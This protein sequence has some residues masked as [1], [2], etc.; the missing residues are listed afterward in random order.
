[1][2]IKQNKHKNVR[3]MR[4][5]YA[6]L[7]FVI[8]AFALMVISSCLYENIALKK[9]LKTNAEETL[10]QME[11]KISSYFLEPQAVLLTIS[12]TIHDIIIQGG[13]VNNVRKYMDEISDDLR[14]K[15]FGYE[16]AGLHCYLDIFDNTYLPTADWEPP[17]N[18]DATS[19]PWYIAA[20]KAAGGIATSPVYFNMRLNNY[21]VTYSQQIF[22]NNGVPLG[23]VALNVPLA[24][25]QDIVV[26]TRLTKGGYGFLLDEQYTIIAHAN[27]NIIG[28]PLREINSEFARIS[29]L[30]DQGSNVSEVLAKNSLGETGIFF[31]RNIENGWHVGLTAL[32]NEYYR[33]LTEMTIIVSILGAIL[34]AALIFVLIRIDAARNRA[35]EANQQK[36]NFLANIS[37]ELRTPLNV[38][39]GLTDLTLEDANLPDPVSENLYKISNAGNTLLSIVNDLLDF[40]KIESGKLSLIPSEYQISSLLNDVVTLVIT[41]LDESPV[42]FN[43]NISDD[44]PSLLYGDDLRIKQIL[45]NLLSNALKYTFSGKIE[46]SVSCTRESSSDI[47][48][49][50]TVSDTGIGIRHEDLAKLFYAYYQV[51]PKANRNMEGTGLGLPITKRLAEMMNGEITVESEFGKGSKFYVTIRQGYVNDEIIGKTVADNLRNFRYSIGK[52]IVAK[53]MVRDDLSSSKVL[54]VDDVPTNLDVAAGL[55]GKYRIHVDCVNSGPSA[56]ERIQRGHPVYN[57]IFM[58]HMMPGMDGIETADRIR[59]LGTEYSLNIPIIALTANAIYGTEQLFL[60]HGFQDFLSKPID[61]M[62]LDSIVKKWVR[63]KSTKDTTLPPNPSPAVSLPNAQTITIPG[64]NTEKV[65]AMYDEEMDLFKSILRSYVTNIPPELEKI[66]TVTHETLPKY[67]IYVHGIKGASANIGAEAIRKASLNLE[68]MAKAG[69]LDGVLK[70]NAQFIKDIENVI[71]N[72]IIWLKL[73]DADGD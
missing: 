27:K 45:N 15:P 36:S 8:L 62:A 31:F 72:I 4:P 41:R 67:A 24:S 14:N 63:G 71:E 32:K 70:L 26:N 42:T 11:I 22:N 16:F 37:H 60:Q 52:H 65:L 29:K 25:I 19:R 54:I 18:F 3:K 28:L 48:M 23:I 55:L 40:S 5:L 17:E 57:A 39:I 56:I 30:L 51:D 38:V 20:V 49:K 58:D 21:A 10:A 44:L 9:H 69:D 1:M 68:T 47:C 34:A 12:K 66:T 7:L 33:E 35:D 64:I 73:N 43:L 59:R 53:K 46:L 2:T 50:M 13:N 6:Q 61:I